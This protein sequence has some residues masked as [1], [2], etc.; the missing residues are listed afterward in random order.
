MPQDTAMKLAIQS[1]IKELMDRVLV[2]VLEEDPFV[3]DTLFLC[4]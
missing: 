2:R 4:K 1:V 3:S